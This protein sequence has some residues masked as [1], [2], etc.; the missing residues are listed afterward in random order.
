MFPSSIKLMI[1]NITNSSLAFGNRYEVNFAVPTGFINGNRQTIENLIVRCDS[2]TIPGR[3]FSTIPY[4]FYGPA[5]NMPYEPIYSGELTASII[6]SADMKER[7]FFEDWMDLICSRSNYKFEY[8]ENYVT[9]FEIN[10]LTKQDQQSYRIL[11]EEAYPKQ[12]GDIQM[13]YDKDNEYLKQ[14]VTFS[15]RKYTPE[16]LGIPNPRL[17]NNPNFDPQTVVQP[18]NYSKWESFPEKGFN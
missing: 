17:G 9:T 4:R 14:D 11:V 5:R 7:Q 3:S 8:Y 12:M 15:F 1:D 18:I 13:G 2:I 16:Y 6:L 10:V